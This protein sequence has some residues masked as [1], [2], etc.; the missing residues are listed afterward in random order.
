MTDV[1]STKDNSVLSLVPLRQGKPILRPSNKKASIPLLRSS[2]GKKSIVL[3]RL[4][5]LSC[6]YAA[7]GCHSNI[8][9]TKHKCKECQ[10]VNQ[11]ATKALSRQMLRISNNEGCLLS[12][13]GTFAAVSTACDP[14]LGNN[15]SSM[16]YLDEEG[17][18]DTKHPDEWRGRERLFPGMRISL[19]ELEG[20][21]CLEFQVAPVNIKTREI[22]HNATNYP[23]EV[24]PRLDGQHLRNHP[25][26]VNR[27]RP[28]NNRTSQTTVIWFCPLGQDLP[29][30]RI[31]LLSNQVRDRGVTVV[32]TEEYRQ[33]THM[34]ISEQ[35]TSLEQLARQLHGCSEDELRQHLDTVRQHSHSR[36]YFILVLCLH[37]LIDDRFVSN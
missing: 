29:R 30:Q 18:S 17:E 14:Q 16:S 10:Q 37:E 3:G 11:W 22:I 31:E 25:Q 7:C 9:S 34:I 24:P 32:V 12:I 20:E 28:N 8:Y 26:N 4:E 15:P 1:P 6:L 19:R 33:A 2:H 23:L 35:V 13:R 27:S 36:S 5:L 21:G